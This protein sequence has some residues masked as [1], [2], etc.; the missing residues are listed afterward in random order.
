M[1]SEIKLVNYHLHGLKHG[2]KERLAVVKTVEAAIKA[3]VNVICFTDHMP[4]PPG[5]IDPVPTQDCAMPQTRYKTYLKQVKKAAKKYQE[6]ITVLQG[7]EVDFFPDSINWTKQQVTD[8][9]LDFVLGSVHFVGTNQKGEN[10]ALDYDKAGFEKCRDNYGGIQGLVREY[11]S[12]VR[13]MAESGVFDSV[14]HLDLVK[15]Y[16]KDKEYFTGDEPWYKTEVLQT[17][18]AIER[19]GIAMELNSSG[20]IKCGEQYPSLW[21]LQEAK[22][23]N[24]PL[25]LGSDGHE[26]GLIA[27]GLR[28]VLETARQA[29]YQS[30]SYF[31]KRQ[32]K[33]MSIKS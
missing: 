9:G 29:G 27:T 16:N 20:L 14:G 26:P 24:I 30:I 7:A 17:L 5:F 4:L 28:E 33:E 2:A 22:E 8:L 31:E 32:R 21:I 13:Q 3:G 25:T 19:S 1:S 18:E 10:L 11:F 6:Q 12:R 23:R 15:K